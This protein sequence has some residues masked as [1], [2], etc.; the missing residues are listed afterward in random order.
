MD[1][2]FLR[3]GGFFSQSGQRKGAGIERKQKSHRFAGASRSNETADADCG[4]NQSLWKDRQLAN[5]GDVQN[6]T[7]SNS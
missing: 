4:S 5:A 7:T 6:N 3:G 1:G 2:I